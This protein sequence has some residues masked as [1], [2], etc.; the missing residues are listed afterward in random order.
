MAFESPR[1]SHH[2]SAYRNSTDEANTPTTELDLAGSLATFG[3]VVGIL[4]LIILLIFACAWVFKRISQSTSLG[5]SQVVKLVSVTSLSPKERLVVVE[6]DERW[7]VL[8][9]TA[10]TITKLDELEKNHFPLVTLQRRFLR[11]CTTP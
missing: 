11:G 9:V 4:V 5:S 2:Q 7:L 1:L 6:V 3:Q 8:G 10:N